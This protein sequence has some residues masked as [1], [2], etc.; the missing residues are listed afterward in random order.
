[1][2]KLIGKYGLA[3]HLALVVVAPLFFT[4]TAVLWLSALVVVW[5]LME[6]SRIGFEQLHNARWR[7]L[8]S[9]WKDAV[10]WVF[11]ALV[12]VA[13]VR[14]A[15]G[16][17]TLAYDAEAA[18][19]S[20]AP[21]K[22]QFLPG[23][24][25]GV[26]YQFFA[27]AVAA[28]VSVTVCRHALG[29]SARFAFYLVAS[30]LSAVGAWTMLTLLY[31]GNA[32]ATGLSELSQLNPVFFGSV[33][34]VHLVGG[35]VG[36]Y[37]TFERRWFKA[38]PFAV[39]AVSGNAAG[40]FVFA[41]P[42]SHCFFAAAAILMFLYAFAYAK[43]SL[44]AHAEFKYMVLFGLSL[45]LG[46]VV[47]GGA[48]DDGIV[49]ARIAPYMTGGFLSPDF[50]SLRALL[51]SISAEIWKA[52][53]WFG[54]GLGSF[55]MEL[56]FHVSKEQWSVIP[57]LQAAPLNGY[58]MLLAERGI[59]GAFLLAVPVLLLAGFYVKSLVLGVMRALPSPAAWTG[60]LVCI[61]AV[62]DMLFSTTM[63]S[64]GLAAAVAAYLSVSTN[65]FP[66]ED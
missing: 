5:F 41:P 49:D 40:L 22:F 57:A 1:M 66:K 15:N 63:L 20:V 52:S 23:S 43:K 53:P 50:M 26:G 60:F 47:V 55:A 32:W 10:F 12:V 39:L 16:G 30:F 59:V 6:P 2:Q 42:I 36:L 4:P 44:P 24:A 65:A 58:W 18:A 37:F 38:M 31:L 14:F 13:G 28:F 17:I 46:T 54:C 9:L 62:G 7:I 45:A 34:G 25:E 51:S 11:L 35:V 21:P 64:P 61:A 56:G 19:W 27:G 48:L 3:A 33:F 29:R 8:S